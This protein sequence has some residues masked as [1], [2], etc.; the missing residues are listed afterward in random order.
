[1]KCDVCGKKVEI[2]F[3]SKVVGA[4]MKNDKRKKKLVCSEC[5]KTYSKKDLLKKL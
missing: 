2:T 4:Y 5:Q 3:L 1:M